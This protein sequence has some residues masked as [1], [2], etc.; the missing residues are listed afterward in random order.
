MPGRSTL[1]LLHAGRATAARMARG[2]VAAAIRIPARAG[3]QLRLVFPQASPRLFVH[4]GARQSLER[5]LRAA[6]AGP[7]VLSITD[8]RHSII[9]HRVQ[10]GTLHA[11]IHH[12]FLDAPAA[13]VDA[14][15]LYVT[16]GDRQSSAALGD[17]IDDNGF[18][19]ARRKKSAP[20]VSK[21]KHHDLLALY[22][23][24]NDRYFDGAVNALI[25]WGK[26]PTRKTRER[27]T[28]KLGSY[29]AFDRL[30]RVHPG[31]DRKWVPRYFVAYI[32]YHE[33]LHHVIPGSR[34]LGRVNLHPP[35]FKAREKE[36]RHFERA[37]AWERRHVGRLLRT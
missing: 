9:T 33:M 19:L 4:E 16:D 13:V 12:M 31:L 8:N 32:V 28:I 18:R 34:G 17:Y 20:L 5:K 6:F 37:L 27:K 7:V 36:F 22:Q 35:E 11:R 24:L 23:K 25:T 10:K 1:P 14:L 15:V 26:G 21:G 2:Y 29:A 3:G 30:I